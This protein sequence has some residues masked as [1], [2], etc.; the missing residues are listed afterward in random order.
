MAITSLTQ[1]F[2]N[3][4]AV[5]EYLLESTVVNSMF[6]TVNS[7]FNSELY[8]TICPKIQCSPN[9]GHYLNSTAIRLLLTNDIQIKLYFQSVTLTLQYSLYRF[10]PFDLYFVF[11]SLFYICTDLVSCLCILLQNAR[12]TGPW[13]VPTTNHRQLSGHFWTSISHVCT[14]WYMSISDNL[15]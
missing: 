12:R 11:Q 13:Q 5:L 4:S 2:T 10:N 3:W 9:F 8:P 15:L 14:P 6:C 1:H 7:Y